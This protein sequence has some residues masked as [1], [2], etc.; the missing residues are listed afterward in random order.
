LSA[1]TDEVEPVEGAHETL[2]PNLAVFIGGSG[3]IALLSF[4]TL[5]W[6]AAVASTVL[7]ALMVA[8]ADVDARTSLLPDLVT[9]GAVVTGLIA[10]ALLDPFDPWPVLGE[11]AARAAILAT[12]L[13]LVRWSYAWLRGREGLGLGDVKLAAGIG[14]WLPLDSIPFCFALAAA[15]GLLCVLLTRQRG[16]G[17]NATLKIPLGAFLCPALWVVFYGTVLPT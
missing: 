10:A 16:N 8:G 9:L 14:A 4:L 17:V 12:S 13:L 7:G 6:P 11:A 1:R 2:R 15:A 5:P 3:A